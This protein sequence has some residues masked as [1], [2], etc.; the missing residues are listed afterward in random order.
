MK[1]YIRQAT[2]AKKGKV[3]F[4]QLIPPHYR[5]KISHQLWSLS[6]PPVI[7]L[8]LFKPN[9]GETTNKREWLC[10]KVEVKREQ[11]L[12]LLAAANSWTTSAA[13]E[14]DRRKGYLDGYRGESEVSRRTGRS[15]RTQR[16]DKLLAKEDNEEGGGI[17]SHKTIRQ[18]EVC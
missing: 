18:F 11:Y 12:S 16:Q 14:A 4:S 10:S 13:R 8:N 3:L 2:A 9:T 15:K 6:D 7:Q 5:T 1:V 17:S